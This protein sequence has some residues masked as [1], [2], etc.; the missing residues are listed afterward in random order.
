LINEG[1]SR[2]LVSRIQNLRK[3]SGF[4]VTDRINLFIECGSDV[5]AAIIK[6]SDYIKSETLSESIVLNQKLDD[7][8]KIE[9]LDGKIK[10]R[11][12]RIL[13]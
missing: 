11:V 6:L 9:F 2:E 12:E 13:V 3:D 4:D 10:L 8:T 7:S 5:E 1:I